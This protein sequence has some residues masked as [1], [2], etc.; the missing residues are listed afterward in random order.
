[1]DWQEAYLSLRSQW[2]TIVL[3]IAVACCVHF[4]Y[5]VIYQVFYH[6]LASFK[7]PL[8]AKIS[9][10]YTIIWELKANRVHGVHK[11]LQR[12]G[13]PVRI[14]P[15]ELAFADEK[16]FNEIYA[17]KS[18]PWPKSSI[19]NT[20]SVTGSGN[21]LSIT[22]RSKHNAVRRL[23]SHAFSMK[24]LRNLEGSIAERVQDYIDIVFRHGSNTGQAFDV[25]HPTGQLALDNISNLTFGQSLD[26]LK[27]RNE[28]APAAVDAVGFVL[29]LTSLAPI[30]KHLPIKTIRQGVKG[31]ERLERLTR[32]CIM[33][34]IKREQSC[35]TPQRQH[36]ILHDLIRALVDHDTPA[37]LRVDEL[38]DNSIIFLVAGTETTTI[39]ICCA[40]WECARSPEVQKRLIAEIRGAFTSP[41]RM[42]TYDE[43]SNLVCSSEP[44][45]K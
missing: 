22:D 14:G 45:F 2:R 21:I 24:N 42:P 15:N 40:L 12:Y 5:S 25:Y 30:L 34:Y 13:S 31:V 4:I 28:F 8:L 39:T 6:P 7:G 19:Y 9:H 27:G 44:A 29:P 17:Q 35:A 36:F 16:S 26:T 38:V 33:D 11:L 32:S 41:D 3:A 23:F 37:S 20:F 18:D 10:I 43:A 1:M